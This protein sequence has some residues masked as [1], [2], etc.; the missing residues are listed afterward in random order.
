MHYRIGF[1]MWKQAARLGV[2]LRLRV[3][4]MR[5]EEANVYIASSADLRGLVCEAST[6]DELVL[7]INSTVQELLEFYLLH[8]IKP[9]LTDLRLTTRANRLGVA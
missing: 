3:D 6:I 9:P 8:D 4:V 7:E 5:D 2:S 1:P